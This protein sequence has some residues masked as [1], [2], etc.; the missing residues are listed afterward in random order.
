MPG[1][2]RHGAKNNDDNES[3]CVR[4]ECDIES[5]CFRTPH[6][7]DD[8]ASTVDASNVDASNWACNLKQAAI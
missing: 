5:E 1:L 2:H 8:D 6:E 3:E 7:S 4:S